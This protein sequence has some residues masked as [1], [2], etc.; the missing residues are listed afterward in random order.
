MSADHG[1]AGSDQQ[2]TA[3]VLKRELQ[4]ERQKREIV[5]SRAAAAERER[6]DWKREYNKLVE[7]SSRIQAELREEI[8]QLENELQKQ[9][10]EATRSEQQAERQKAGV[11]GSPLDFKVQICYET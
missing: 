8:S 4:E 7:D 1:A 3:E 10:N 9:R 11:S 2:N 5:Q 6:E